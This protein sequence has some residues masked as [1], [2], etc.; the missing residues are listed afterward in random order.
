MSRPARKPD[1]SVTVLD[2]MPPEQPIATLGANPYLAMVDKAIANNA[3]MDV[4]ERMLA[5]QE[6]WEANE[7]RKAYVAAMAEFKNQEIVILKRKRVFYEPNGKPPVEYFHAELADVCNEVVP[8]LAKVGISHRWDVKQEAGAITVRCTLT[9]AMGHSESVEMMA[10]PDDSGGKNKIQQIASTNTYLQRYTL[11]AITGLATQGQD[12]DGR[13]SEDDDDGE[14]GDARTEQHA[15]QSPAAIAA[16]KAK[17]D[18]ALG[19]HSESITF[20]KDRIAADD[21][22]AALAEWRAFPFDDQIAL[23]LA[24]SAGGCLTTKERAALHGAA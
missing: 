17:H 7:A 8:A 3:A 24:P 21:I 11:L 19:R 5:L 15:S 9:H 14:A 10:L 4:I 18:E 6:R 1:T 13:S 2:T 20:I 16:R 12:D 23:W 22:A